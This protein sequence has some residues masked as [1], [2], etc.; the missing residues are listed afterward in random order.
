ML[1]T[2]RAAADAIEQ[3]IET[4]FSI[5][6]SPTPLNK[7]DGALG[8]IEVASLKSAKAATRNKPGI[9]TSTY[10][11]SVLSLTFAP[12]IFPTFVRTA[13]VFAQHRL[14]QNNAGEAPF[15]FSSILTGTGKST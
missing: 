13:R 6:L 12:P 1:N 15:P 9:T 14:G 10:T 4:L 2:S 11:W 8:R 3:E 5:V 7:L